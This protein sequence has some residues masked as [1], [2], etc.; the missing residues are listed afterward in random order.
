M[1]ESV[2]QHFFDLALRNLAVRGR[3]VVIGYVSEYVDGPESVT[4][5]RVYTQILQKS[6]SIRSFFL[7]HFAPYYAEHVQRLVGL[8]QAGELRVEIDDRPFEGVGGVVDAVEH[9]HSGASRGKV[10][11]R[12]S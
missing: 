10:V 4:G 12:M 9:L 7:P 6:A 3:L 8:M 2:G 11:V 5:P 1:Y